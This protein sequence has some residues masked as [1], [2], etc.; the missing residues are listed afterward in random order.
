MGDSK[1]ELFT[2]RMNW[3]SGPK[4]DKCDALRRIQ[5]LSPSGKKMMEECICKNNISFY[6][7]RTHICSSFEF[8]NGKFMAWYKPYSDADGM[9][10]EYLGG[11][12]VPRII[13]SGECFE[14]IQET[15]YNV[16]FR[17]EE[18]CQAYCDWLTEKEANKLK[19]R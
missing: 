2:A 8:R 3:K 14:S 16:Y 19:E 18:D 13:Y 15:H 4:C 11:S 17:T 9:E 7:P 1:M 12:S 6:A 5:F 10:L